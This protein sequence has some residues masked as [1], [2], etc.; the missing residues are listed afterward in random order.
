MR[1]RPRGERASSI[2][3][4]ARARQ[5]KAPRARAGEEEEDAAR[6]RGAVEIEPGPHA[7]ILEPY[8]FSELLWYFAFSSLNALACLEGRSYLSGRLGEKLFDERF[9]LVD[10]G[11]DPLGMPKAFDLEGVPKQRV[12]IVERGVATDVV[13]DRR[14]A[15]RA[16][17]GGESTGHS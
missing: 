16:G 12:T 4:P 9:T 6:P 7:A 5:R 10:D 14:S 17:E 2:P 11:L 8:A 15:K 13:C 1:K 3:L